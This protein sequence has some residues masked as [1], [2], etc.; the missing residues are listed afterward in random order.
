ME[1][2]LEDW[3]GRGPGDPDAHT[4]PWEQEPVK[5]VHATPEVYKQKHWSQTVR[6]PNSTLEP[7]DQDNWAGSSEQGWA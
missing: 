1:Q 7:Q 4:P 3:F 6:N 5:T 2:D